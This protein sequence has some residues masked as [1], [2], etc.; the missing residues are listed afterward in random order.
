VHRVIRRARERAAALLAAVAAFGLVVAPLVHS[1][2]HLQELSSARERA[3][4]RVFRL[5]FDRNRTIQQE[6]ALGEALEQA[7]GSGQ[8][9]GAL[10]GLAR[11]G[12]HGPRGHSHDPGGHSH[13]PG[14]HGAGSLQHFAL[15]VHGAPPPPALLPPA[16]VPVAPLLAQRS[17][18]FTP[19]YTTPEQAQAPPEI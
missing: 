4:A 7:F 1:E 16:Q 19:R 8:G 2:A 14:Q 9:S 17:P 15:A 13:G 10:D 11:A 5:G 3:L 6:R 18:L 12:A